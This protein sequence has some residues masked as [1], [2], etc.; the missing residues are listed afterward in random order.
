MADRRLAAVQANGSACHM[1]LG[2]QGVQG[3][4][5]V[6]VDSAQLIHGPGV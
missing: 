6:Q 3:Q 4:K 2:E 5:Q 1:P